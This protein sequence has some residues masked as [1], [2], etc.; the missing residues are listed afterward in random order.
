MLEGKACGKEV[1]FQEKGS[2]HQQPVDRDLCQVYA[3]AAG[4]PNATCFPGAAACQC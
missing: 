3:T 4:C 2:G 1:F